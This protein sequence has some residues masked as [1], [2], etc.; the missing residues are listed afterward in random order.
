MRQFRAPVFLL[1]FLGGVF[2]ANAQDAA[3]DTGA[4]LA[5]RIEAGSS[6]GQESS[7]DLKAALT[8]LRTRSLEFANVYDAARALKSERAALRIA[9]ALKDKSAIT[10]ILQSIGLMLYRQ[11]KNE[12]ALDT[13]RI[14]LKLA[15][16]QDDKEH[17]AR[18]WRGIS[19][20]QAALSRL[21]EAQDAQRNALNFFQAIDNQAEVA[22]CLVDLAVEYSHMGQNQ[23]G[24]EHYKRGLELAEAIQAP[25]IVDRALEGLA[26][27]YTV[28]GDY[29]VALSYLERVQHAPGS[30]LGDRRAEAYFYSKLGNLYLKTSHP[31]TKETLNHGL[32]LAREV[33]DLRLAA[34]FLEAL[35]GGS[36]APEAAEES[37]R[38][39][40]ELV[41]IY[42]QLGEADQQAWALSMAAQ[43][44]ITLKQMGEAVA[45]G[46]KAVEILRDSVQPEYR[47]MAFLQL[48]RAYRATGKREEAEQALRE[49]MG[50]VESWR[51]G[52][53]GGQL[54]GAKFLDPLLGS[55]QELMSMRVEDGAALDALQIA[56]R[57]KARRLLDVI[58]EGKLDQDRPLSPEEKEHEQ[59]LAA[60]AAQWNVRLSKP[61]FTPQDKAAFEKAARDLGAYRAELFTAHSSLRNRRGETELITE[62]GL[63]SLL[64]GSNALLVEFA[65]G[66]KESFV[67]TVSRGEDGHPRVTAKKLAAGEKDLGRRVEDFRKA[68]ATRDLDYRQ[69]ARDLYCD[70][71]APIEEELKGRRTV[72]IV[73]DGA[74]WNLPF[75]ALVDPNNKYLIEQTALYYAPSLT[76][77]HETN[78]S[79]NRTVG[80]LKPLVAAGAGTNDLRFAAQEV[81]Q[82]AKLYGPSSVALTGAEATEKRWKAE[83]G[84]A[85]VLH[86]ATHG[87]L[88]S[89]NPLFSYLQLAK[90]SDG[91]E[92]GMLEARELAD[93]SLHADLVVLSACETGRGEF[94]SGE[95]VLGMSW[96]VLTAGTPT[97]V[98]SQWKVDSASTTQLM[99]GFHRTIAPAANGMGPIRGKAQALRKAMLDL[100]Q[101][102]KYQ[103]PFYWAGFEMLGDGY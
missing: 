71:L 23:A 34:W 53:A 57:L 85:R 41:R 75:Q 5:D 90:D 70:L 69:P 83:A 45:D 44:H 32:Q 72:G 73:P 3:Q 26:A 68:L 62:S 39:F 80:G 13:Y 82:L 89:T 79:G 94:V 67:F 38:E 14:G 76:V 99:L 33:N 88:N 77:L 42:R 37:L 20:A 64:P 102:P 11:G 22:N 103:H 95:G 92:D 63:Q 40:D 81:S 56:E 35:A 10:S 87:I 6:F 58:R 27:L 93:L 12:E 21:Q 47:T 15:E 19:N 36:D 7:E 17:Q 28:Q 101:T 25:V 65:F 24:A 60:E 55:Y 16:D 29:D 78:I 84:R 98:V 61:G 66:A 100:I 51:K 4:T 18:M 97:A 9:E 52:I 50:I 86:V 74:L 30:S 46:E 43:R 31:A 49:S 1:L 54:N 2:A 48:G 59:A 8:V 91:E 96:A